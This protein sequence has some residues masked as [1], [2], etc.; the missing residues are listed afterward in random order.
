LL[1]ASKLLQGQLVG[2]S[3]WGGVAVFVGMIGVTLFGVLLTPV[4]YYVLSGWAGAPP[5]VPR[6]RE[7]TDP[8]VAAAMGGTTDSLATSIQEK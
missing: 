5:A 2:Y 3:S 6:T 8:V 4:F 1:E 7:T